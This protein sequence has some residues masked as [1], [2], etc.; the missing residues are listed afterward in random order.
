MQMEIN[1]NRGKKKL[2]WNV[3]VMSLCLNCSQNQK[4]REKRARKVETFIHYQQYNACFLCLKIPRPNVHRSPEAQI[5]NSGNIDNKL[6]CFL[7]LPPS[8]SLTETCL[9]C[10]LF[11]DG[12]AL[13]L[14]LLNINFLVLIFQYLEQI[15]I[16]L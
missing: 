4:I 13:L 8:A 1:G 6:H 12:L 9:L 2:N 3:T 16:I 7:S 11:T 10:S 5:Q 15:R 14:I